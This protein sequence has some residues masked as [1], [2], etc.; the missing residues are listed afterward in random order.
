MEP[1]PEVE[2]VAVSVVIANVLLSISS[3]PPETEAAP[4]TDL[5]TE[6]AARNVP[7]EMERSELIVTAPF[8]VNVEPDDKVSLLNV[9]AVIVWAEVPLNSAIEFVSSKAAVPTL[10]AQLPFNLI[11]FSPPDVSTPT[12]PPFMVKLPDSSTFV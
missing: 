10:F 11:V 6:E 3:D 9:S 8:A 2:S 4:P 12:E 5:V 7:D 1:V